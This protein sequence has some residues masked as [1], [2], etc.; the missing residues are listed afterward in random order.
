[1]TLIVRLPTQGRTVL[2]LQPAKDPGRTSVSLS[3]VRTLA[4]NEPY[5][6]SLAD[7]QNLGCTEVII[8]IARDACAHQFKF[9]SRI[10]G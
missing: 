5:F 4:Y 2:A 8:S 1:M 9:Q 6:R 10:F 7:C 3:I